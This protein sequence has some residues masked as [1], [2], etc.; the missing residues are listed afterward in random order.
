MSDFSK[1]LKLYNDKIEELELEIIKKSFDLQYT[2]IFL[3]KI[4]ERKRKLLTS[5]KR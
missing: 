2:K 3:K 5:F 1:N 4:E